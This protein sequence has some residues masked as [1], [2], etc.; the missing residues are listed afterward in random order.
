MEKHIT[1]VG[2]LNIVYRSFLLVG[3]CVL[4]ALAFGF[5]R[6]MNFLMRAGSV[7]PDE[8]PYEIL[9]IVPLLLV[10]IGG[11]IFVVSLAGIIGGVGVL[12]RKEWGR[13]LMLVVSFFN[14]A[15]VPLGTVLGVYTLWVLLNNDTIRLF[16]PPA[17]SAPA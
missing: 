15:H 1:L 9:D 6:L 2:V 12:K 5:G 8:I 10:M 14:L 17:Q 11:L 13:I 16:N 4:F 3:A 7:H